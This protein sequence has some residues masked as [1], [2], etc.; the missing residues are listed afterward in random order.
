M[1]QAP[2]PV[3]SKV[4]IILDIGCFNLAPRITIILSIHPLHLTI[5]IIYIF[6]LCEFKKASPS[7]VV[8]MQGTF[9]MQNV[10]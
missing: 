1:I 3:K 7:N 2:C 10:L 9:S 8:G 4:E 6:N 5:M